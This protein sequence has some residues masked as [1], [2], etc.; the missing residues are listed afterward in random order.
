MASRLILLCLEKGLYPS[1]DAANLNSLGLA[2]KLGYNYDSEYI[3]Y[4]INEE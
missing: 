4:I 1:W 3:I 2:R